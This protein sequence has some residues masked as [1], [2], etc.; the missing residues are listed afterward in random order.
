[1]LTRSYYPKENTSRT[2]AADSRAS[3]LARKTVQRQHG[4]TET[5][6]VSLSFPGP[7]S[8]PP[9]GNCSCPSSVPGAATI[10]ATTAALATTAATTTSVTTPATATRYVL[11]VRVLFCAVATNL[12][13]RFNRISH[14]LIVLKQRPVGSARRCLCKYTR[15]SHRCIMFV[16]LMFSIYM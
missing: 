4:Y 2:H 1:L 16:S 6:R 15:I 5:V 13:G 9:R 10:S 7:C 8:R 12:K 3:R 11:A 14:C